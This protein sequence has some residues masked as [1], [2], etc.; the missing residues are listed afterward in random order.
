VL[1][2]SERPV[3][4]THVFASTQ[5]LHAGR[6]ERLDPGA[7]D[8]VIACEVHHAKAPTYRRLLEHLRP[9]ILLGLTATPERGDGQSIVG[10]FDGAWRGLRE[11]GR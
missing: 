9:E 2:G 6:L 11:A 7:Y 8:V 4:G 5:S 3:R 10:W 1:V